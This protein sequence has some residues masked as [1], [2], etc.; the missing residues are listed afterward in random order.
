MELRRDI[1]T[2][3]KTIQKE[4]H[5]SLYERFQIVIQKRMNSKSIS[6]D[7]KWNIF[8]GPVDTSWVESLNTVLDDSKTPYFSNRKRIKQTPTVA[9][10]FEVENLD[11][12]FPATVS[13]CGMVYIDPQNFPWRALVKSWIE[14]LPSN[15]FNADRKKVCNNY[16][17]NYLEIILNLT[18][19]MLEMVKQPTPIK[20]DAKQGVK[21]VTDQTDFEVWTKTIFFYVDVWGVGGSL[22]ET[23]REQ[24]D[25][26]IRKAIEG[27]FLPNVESVFEVLPN[28]ETRKMAV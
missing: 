25:P 22:H 20:K 16:F 8:D 1:Q 17:K 12:A 6:I 5:K 10:L 26:I 18:E 27:I 15:T 21:S 4:M 19:N 2:E 3:T 24:F 28:T 14:E 7:D 23:A 9:L 13:I 11:V